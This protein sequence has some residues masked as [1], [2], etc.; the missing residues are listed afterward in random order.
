MRL[1]VP[2]F[3]LGDAKA[4][5]QYAMAQ[6]HKQKTNTQEI[7]MQTPALNNDEIVAKRTPRTTVENERRKSKKNKLTLPQTQSNK[8]CIGRGGDKTT[9]GK[10]ERKQIQEN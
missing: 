4:K 5:A 9:T 6:R 1:P 8:K 10:W 2:E 7:P 3:R